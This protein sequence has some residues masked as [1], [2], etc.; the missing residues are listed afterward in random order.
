MAAP[1]PPGI[2]VAAF[3]V[4]YV[5]GDGAEHHVPLAVA[6][7]VPFEQ[8]LPVRRFA[9]QQGQRHLSGL[10]WSAAT[11]AHVGFESWLERDHLLALDF[12]PAVTGI[13]SGPVVNRA[14]ATTE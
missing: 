11:S 3:E 14:G 7:A 8:A 2:S 1:L 12:D 9:S 6:L 13:A 4:G 10:W 5:S